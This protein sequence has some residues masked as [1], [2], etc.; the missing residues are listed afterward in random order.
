MVFRVLYHFVR[1]KN[2]KYRL[3]EDYYWCIMIANNVKE[4]R[5][6]SVSD[7][8]AFA[9]E[10]NPSDCMHLTNNQL[11][12][13]CHAWEKYSEFWSKYIPF[14]LKQNFKDVNC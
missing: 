2:R 6:A 8:L 14:D 3:A 7:A 1:F 13:G 10:R 12:F 5:V 11:P 9:F 4:Y